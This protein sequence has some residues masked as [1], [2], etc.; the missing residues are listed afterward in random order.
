MERD[1]APHLKDEPKEKGV[2][3][4]EAP[5]EGTGIAIT[6]DEPSSN[7]WGV[8]DQQDPWSSVEA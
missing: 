1:R 7:S 4:G 6:T 5:S 3:E 2:G 8:Q